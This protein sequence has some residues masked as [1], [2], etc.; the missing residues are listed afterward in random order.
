MGCDGMADQTQCS[1]E[2]TKICLPHFAGASL[3]CSTY[4]LI[5]P[6]GFQLNHTIA[7]VLGGLVTLGVLVWYILWAKKQYAR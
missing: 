7:Y 5:A 6:E 4:I 2:N 3:V 1:R